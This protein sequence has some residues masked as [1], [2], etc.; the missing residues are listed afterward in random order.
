M[1]TTHSIWYVT[2]HNTQQADSEYAYTDFFQTK[3][4]AEAFIAAETADS[5]TDPSRSWCTAYEGPYWV[6]FVIDTD[7][8]PSLTLSRY[9]H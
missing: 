1:I 2:S 4:E 5:G 8:S 7:K 3:E 9:S 6:S